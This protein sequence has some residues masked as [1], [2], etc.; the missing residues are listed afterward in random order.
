MFVGAHLL[1][2]SEVLVL[3]FDLVFGFVNLCISVLV[4]NLS[5]LKKHLLVAHVIVQLIVVSLDDPLLLALHN[6][7]VFLFSASVAFDIL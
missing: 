7:L 5:L 6:G 1:V 3:V 4:A 2:K